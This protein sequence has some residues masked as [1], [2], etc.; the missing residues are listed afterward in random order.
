MNIND[1]HP[2]L[3]GSNLESRNGCVA[4]FDDMDDARKQLT[5]LNEHIRDS[6]VPAHTEITTATTNGKI[7]VYYQRHDGQPWP[8]PD[9]YKRMVGP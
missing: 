6:G 8:P 7:G 2:H 1:L 4:F 3:R 5:L 9:K